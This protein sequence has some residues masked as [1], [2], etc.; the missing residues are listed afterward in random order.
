M[1]IK[2]RKRRARLVYPSK[3]P[4]LLKSKRIREVGR[5]RPRAILEV[6]GKAKDERSLKRVL[7]DYIKPREKLKSHWE[8]KKSKPGKTDA[9]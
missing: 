7:V 1:T 5:K 3:L 4:P 6:S 2:A 8:R 9:F